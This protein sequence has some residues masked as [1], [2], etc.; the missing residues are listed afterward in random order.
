MLFWYPLFILSLFVS[1]FMY[2]CVHLHTEIHSMYLHMRVY[3]CT[4]IFGYTWTEQIR[5]S[6]SYCSLNIA[7]NK[8][9]T[10]FYFLFL[11]PCVCLCTFACV[12]ACTN[13]KL[14]TAVFVHSCLWLN[15][16]CLRAE[17]TVTNPGDHPWPLR[18]L[19]INRIILKSI[20]K[21][22][23]KKRNLWFP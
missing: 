2:I 22:E 8:T 11:S 21:R 1:L 19:N 9:T 6:N 10:L 23:K 20:K 14:V 12:H 17:R 3:I 13:K 4:H 7:Q 5:V 15:W 16:M 18:L